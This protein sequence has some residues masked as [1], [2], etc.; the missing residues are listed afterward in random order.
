MQKIILALI[1]FYQRYFSSMFGP[2]CRFQPSC[3]AYAY[4]SIKKYGLGK[5][6]AKAMMRLLRCHPFCA[7]GDDPVHPHTKNF[8]E[9]VK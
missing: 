7:G 4:E 8:S 5:G 1:T 6:T 3:S 2:S 9:G